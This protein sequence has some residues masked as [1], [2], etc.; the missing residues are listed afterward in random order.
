M[1]EQDFKLSNAVEMALAS[2]KRAVAAYSEAAEN[3]PHVALKSLFTGLSGIEQ[4]HYDKLAELALSLRKQGKFIAY[5]PC[6]ISIEELPQ[7]EIA[8]VTKDVLS[9]KKV[10]LMDV[11]TSA[12]DIEKEFEELYTSLAGK[13]SDPEGKAMFEWLAKEE[14][15]HLEIM[16]K[17]Y[18]NV[19]HHGL[20]SSPKQ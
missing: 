5:E 3:A 17:L 15:R 9:G 7:V 16:T 20:P 4:Y 11:L 6:S 12:Q 2:E 8:S 19:S 1:S 13:T 18:W 14:H 10:S